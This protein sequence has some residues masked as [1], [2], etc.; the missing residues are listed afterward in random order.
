M[1]H[2]RVAP[3]TPDESGPLRPT[4]PPTQ[5]VQRPLER[6]SAPLPELDGRPG[7]V[8]RQWRIGS[9]GDRCR[10]ASTASTRIDRGARRLRGGSPRVPLGAVRCL[11]GGRG[12]HERGRQGPRGLA[13]ARIPSGA[14]GDDETTADIVATQIIDPRS[15]EVTA[16]SSTRRRDRPEPAT[17][18]LPGRPSTAAS[19]RRGRSLPP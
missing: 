14:P 2:Q 16:V 17:G 15:R 12:V 9:S 5:R 7:R 4:G 11:H 6:G 1:C 10:G 8:G 18:R 13:T 19:P 3:D